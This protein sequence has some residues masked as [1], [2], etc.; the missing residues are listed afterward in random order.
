[1]PHNPQKKVICR[2]K[3]PENVTFQWGK[4]W[5]CWLLTHFTSVVTRRSFLLDTLS[6][7]HLRNILIA[8]RRTRLK[9]QLLN[10]L[11]KLLLANMQSQTKFSVCKSGKWFCKNQGRIYDLRWHPWPQMEQLRTPSCNKSA[12]AFR[13]SL[14]PQSI[15]GWWAVCSCKGMDH[16]RNWTTR[17][18]S[19]LNGWIRRASLIPILIH[20]YDRH[21][22]MN[23]DDFNANYDLKE[24]IGST[25]EGTQ[26][27]LSAQFARRSARTPV[28]YSQ[29]RCITTSSWKRK[30]KSI[31]LSDWITLASWTFTSTTKTRD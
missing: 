15:T 20:L 5:S 22:A 7:T 19:R 9:E 18:F 1:M 16:C 8:T 10:Q 23:F 24:L 29:R 25:Q 26:V 3:R 4:L 17:V 6:R 2:K 12:K 21:I 11:S 27:G 28:K 14:I 13:S 30:M 31:C